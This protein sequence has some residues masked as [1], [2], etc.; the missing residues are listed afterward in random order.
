MYDTVNCIKSEYTIHLARAWT[1]NDFQIEHSRK[2][3][4]HT[5]RKQVCILLY[6]YLH[7][8]I[9]IEH[10]HSKSA[11]EECKFSVAI[12]YA[13]NPTLLIELVFAAAQ[14]LLQSAFF[15][16]KMTNI[17]GQAQSR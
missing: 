5:L 6:I 3:C 1:V 8:S 13:N 2:F 10:S 7:D 15:H 9:A 4:T 14:Y 16:L 12:I 11:K 17:Y